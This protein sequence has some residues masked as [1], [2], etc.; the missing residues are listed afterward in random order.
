MYFFFLDLHVICSLFSDWNLERSGYWVCWDLRVS[1]GPSP[2]WIRICFDRI[3]PSQQWPAMTSNYYFFFLNSHFWTVSFLHFLWYN[4]F[5][6][7]HIYLNIIK[8]KLESAHQSKT[9]RNQFEPFNFLHKTA[10]R[11][12]WIEHIIKNGK[13]LGEVGFG[14]GGVDNWHLYS[15]DNT[16]VRSDGV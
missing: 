6:L 2:N 3:G 4:N 12:G 10:Y 5:Q 14:S 1:A 15:L 8:P 16:I 7:D 9:W 11:Y 13:L